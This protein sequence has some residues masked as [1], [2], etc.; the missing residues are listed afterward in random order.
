MKFKKKAIFGKEYYALDGKYGEEFIPA[1]GMF[2]PIWIHYERLPQKLPG[3]FVG[4]DNITN[5]LRVWI[6]INGVVIERTVQ[7]KMISTVRE[8]D[9]WSS[10]TRIRRLDG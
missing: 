10:Q 8:G 6:V 4:F 7:Q 3:V 1:N 5:D 2:Y 9:N